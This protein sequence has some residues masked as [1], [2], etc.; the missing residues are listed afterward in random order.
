L[1]LSKRLSG[2]TEEAKPQ[3]PEKENK[4]ASFGRLRR[5]AAFLQ[6]EESRKKQQPERVK[7]GL[8][9]YLLVK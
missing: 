3:Q 1:R 7:R 2:K 9:T 5:F 6:K 8:A 4:N